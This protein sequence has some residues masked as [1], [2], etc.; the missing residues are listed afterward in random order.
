MNNTRIF[1]T[2]MVVLLTTLCFSTAMAATTVLNFLSNPGLVAS[3]PGSNG[4]GASGGALTQTSFTIDGYAFASSGWSYYRDGVHDGIQIGQPNRLT[5]SRADGQ[6]FNLEGF[7]AFTGGT[8]PDA[9]LT[10]T[11]C[12]DV[13]CTGGGTPYQYPLNPN[14]VANPIFGSPPL[15]N[16]L[17][18]NVDHLVFDITTTFGLQSVRLSIGTRLP[19]T[20]LDA[21]GMA[22]II[23]RNTVGR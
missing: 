15:T 11:A 23:W 3:L 14:N 12:P 2:V 4:F 16:P 10:V 9:N 5:V 6:P 20:D 1:K 19:S 7:I 22:D 17:I 21:D 13:N 18:A 8:Q